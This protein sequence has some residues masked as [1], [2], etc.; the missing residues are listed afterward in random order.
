MSRAGYSDDLTNWSLIRYRGQVA[1]ATR[2]K[3]G[4]EFLR[5]LRDSLDALPEKKLCDGDLE[6]PSGRVCAIG[7][8]GKA[9]G[10]DMTGMDAEIM[11]EDGKLG[12]MFN[13]ADPLVREIEFVNDD[14]EYQWYNKRD[15]ETLQEYIDRR[16]GERWIRIR[17]WVDQQIIRIE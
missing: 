3:R 14:S 15:N 6:Q 17:N 10:I 11:T 16:D 5:E 1:S 7:A 12:E 13:I 8:V 9:R 4:Q 2:G